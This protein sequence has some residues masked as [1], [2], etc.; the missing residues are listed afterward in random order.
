VTP[1]QQR[2][3]R[4]LREVFAIYVFI[5][6]AVFFLQRHMLYFPDASD[7]GKPKDAGVPEMSAVHVKTADGLDLVGWFA[8]PARKT[9]YI[10]VL[11][12]G[13]AGNIA[14]RGFKARQFLDRGYGVMLSEYRGY[15]GNPGSPTEQGLYNDGRA[16]LDWLKGLGYES[17]QFVL[18]GESVGTGVAV[19]M[20]LETQPKFLILESPFSSAAAVAKKS[21][22]WMPVDF[23]M[24]DRYDSIDKIGKVK[25]DLLIVHGGSDDIISVQLGFDLFEA[26]KGKKKFFGVKGGGHNDLWTFNAGT[27]IADWLDKQVAGQK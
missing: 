14:M 10:V 18:Y 12:H 19:Q 7:P 11:F 21:Y 13:N 22:W 17:S 4:V 5:V 26:A 27:L 23:M 3:F 25:S 15:G 24:H 6:V 8:P 1:K 9:G 2:I 20:A 16:A